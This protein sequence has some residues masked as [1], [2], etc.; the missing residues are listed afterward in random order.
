MPTSWCSTWKTQG[1]FWWSSWSTALQNLVATSKFYALEGWHE[2]SS[3]VRTHNSG[4]KHA[5]IWCFPLGKVNFYTFLYVR[6]KTAAIVPKVLAPLYLIY[7]QR[8]LSIHNLCTSVLR[9]DYVNVNRTKH[10]LDI[11]IRS[12]L[13]SEVGWVLFMPPAASHSTPLK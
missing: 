3:I 8:W 7:S 13:I 11:S 6:A 12:I 5:V 4:V 2:T 1:M 10:F 9:T